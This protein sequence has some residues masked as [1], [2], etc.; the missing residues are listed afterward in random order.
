VV[1]GEIRKLSDQSKQTADEIEKL[2]R[3]IDLGLKKLS[4]LHRQPFYA[5]S[6][7]G[8]RHEEVS[9][10]VM[11]MAEVAEKLTTLAKTL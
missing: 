6:G 10:T 9:A 7:A 11:E 3:A 5:E 2:I 4:Q 8:S 1:A